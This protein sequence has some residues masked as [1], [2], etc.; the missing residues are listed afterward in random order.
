MCGNGAGF[1]DLDGK[2]E[3]VKEGEEYIIRL[4]WQGHTLALIDH[5]ES[6]ITTR[7]LVLRQAQ[8][9]VKFLEKESGEKLPEVILFEMIKPESTVFKGSGK[10]W[11]DKITLLVKKGYFSTTVIAHELAHLLPVSP[12]NQ[13]GFFAEGRS[14]Y[15]H[16]KFFDTF[17]AGNTNSFEGI[18]VSIDLLDSTD[19]IK[20]KVNSKYWASESTIL[21]VELSMKEKFIMTIE[22]V[23]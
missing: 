21:L 19:E 3:M 17:L 16:F 2:F 7:L 20:K 4:K 8:Q 13:T 10:F 9:S 14:R 22:D 1:H 15:F 6:D 23:F 11:G 12:L 5:A 18:I